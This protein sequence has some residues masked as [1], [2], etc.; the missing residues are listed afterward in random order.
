MKQI[1]KEILKI[2]NE[3][4]FFV[5]NFSFYIFVIASYI[6]DLNK[7]GIYYKIYM[8]VIFI[9]SVLIF[10]INFIVVKL[11]YY[12]YNFLIIL[13]FVI[14]ILILLF[15]NK[16][17]FTVINYIYQPVFLNILIQLPLSIFSGYNL[18]FFNK[19]FKYIETFILIF[20]Y[21]NT[22]VMSVYMISK[23]NIFDG[24][25]SFNSEIFSYQSLS[26][27]IVY[28][29]GFLLYFIAN[30]KFKKIQTI[31]NYSFLLI[32]FTQLMFAGGRGAFV[33]LLVYLMVYYKKLKINNL[34]I[35]LITIL[36]FFIFV[37]YYDDLV[38]L[39]RILDFIV[40]GNLDESTSTR[41]IIYKNA[42]NSL[43]NTILLP[44]GLGSAYLINGINSHNIILDVF[45]EL[46][47]FLGNIFILLIIFSFAKIIKLMIFNPSFEIIF[48]IFISSLVQLF[49]SSYYLENSMFI[50]TLS[51]TF[52]YSFN[53]TAIGD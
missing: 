40:T 47:L 6:F 24:S 45:I 43:K 33:L 11:K 46:G 27:L 3:S 16:L 49:F 35:I 7:T 38:G 34:F 14:S 19:K 15:L 20:I 1:N 10:L 44:K 9:F 26:Y 4:L 21:V 30:K 39:K 52:F 32:L 22:I 5:V 37:N 17:N 51:F 36:I 28:L 25:N 12:R 41:L 8:I 2:I 31:I 42:I 13:F 23:Y 18:I 50:S 29:I 53:I 48:I